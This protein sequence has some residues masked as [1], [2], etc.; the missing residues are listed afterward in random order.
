MKS[1]RRREYNNK[2][3]K[4]L[5]TVFTVLIDIIQNASLDPAVGVVSEY[6]TL[7]QR[8]NQVYLHSCKG[9]RIVTQTV[10]AHL[11]TT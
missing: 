9:K 7:P 1:G 2:R 11:I 10:A 4:I 5:I 6:Q 3:K 8:K